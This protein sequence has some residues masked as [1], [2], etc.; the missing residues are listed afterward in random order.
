MI[1]RE[2]ERVAENMRYQKAPPGWVYTDANP[3]TSDGSYGLGWSSFCILDIDDDQFTT[4]KS[5]D[6]PFS[7]RFGQRVEHLETRLIDFLRYENAQGRTVIL[8]FPDD[9]DI[10]T[11]VTQALSQMPKP[12]TVRPE[13]PEIIIHSTTLDAW[14][15][16]SAEG[17]LKA[18]SELLRQARII[19]PSSEVG[20]YLE[21]EPPEYRDYI[22]FGAIASTTP[23]KIVAS[24]QTGRFI[25]D[26]DAVYE[27]GV[28][29]YF[30]NYRMIGDHQIVRDGL[31]TVKVY[32]RLS[33]SPYLLAVIGVND[34]D[35]RREVKMWTPR[36][37]VERA[38]K[39]FYD[40][41]HVEGKV[42]LWSK[43]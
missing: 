5:G 18:A 8:S 32:K 40:K 37:F 27:P 1:D 39:A 4:G 24:Y 15:K 12:D 13:D 38:D 25:L 20:R 30:D 17:Q 6:G 35:P 3:F 7:A 29:L 14:E 34:L 26:D 33:L 23:E 43:R 2:H 19:D 31:H 9:I 11:Y 21:N 28:R 22:M 10:D 42:I 16:I 41:I 36:L